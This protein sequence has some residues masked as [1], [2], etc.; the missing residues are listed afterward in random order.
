M[1][2]SLLDF[3]VTFLHF[4]GIWCLLGLITIALVTITIRRNQTDKIP[5]KVFFF[6]IAFVFIIFFSWVFVSQINPHYCGFGYASENFKVVAANDNVLWGLD[7]YDNSSKYGGELIR[8]QGVDL[9]N[10]E[11]LFTKLVGRKKIKIQGTK[12]QFVWALIDKEIIGMNL[13]TGKNSFLI[14]KKY[15]MKAFPELAGGVHQFYY[16]TKTSLIDIE[17]EIGKCFSIDPNTSIKVNK[18]I[19]CNNTEQYLSKTDINSDSLNKVILEN[20]NSKANHNVEDKKVALNQ[21]ILLFDK[22]KQRFFTLNYEN[23]EKENFIIKCN[24]LSGELIWEAKQ[25]HLKVS[26]IFNKTPTY[27]RSFFYKDKIIFVFCGYIFS[28]NASN[29]GLNWLTRM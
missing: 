21:E 1:L 10:G 8:I 28:L 6:L 19:E 4:Y 13:F 18:T 22:P 17:P 11:K 14:N 2:T 12:N 5:R 24:N 16:N 23:S 26:N 27:E 3:F 9:E 20:Q 15:L 29:G 25:D 7:S